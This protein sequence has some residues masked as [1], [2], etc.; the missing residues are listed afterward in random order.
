MTLSSVTIRRAVAQEAADISALALRSKAHWGYSEEFLEMCRSEL[1]YSPD[2]CAS[3]MMWVAGRGAELLG[4]YLIEGEG[5]EGELAAMF[6]APEHIGTGV[7][8]TLLRH[9]LEQA[10]IAGFHRLQLD[11]D[12]GAESFYRHHG[13]RRIGRSPSGSIPG[14]TLPRLVFDVVGPR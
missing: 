4:F 12:P 9:A 3:G 5:P 10:A 1:T 14:R 8:G 13:A 7:G 6:V 2:Q 11:A